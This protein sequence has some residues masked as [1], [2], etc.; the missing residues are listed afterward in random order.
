MAY[1]ALVAGTPFLSSAG[2]IAAIIIC[3][4]SILFI[5]LTLALSVAS[6][7]LFRWINTQAALVKLLRPTVETV[8]KTTAAV[9]RGSA[10]TENENKI[11][12]TIAQGPERVKALDKQV[13]VL[14]DRVVSYAIE[15]RARTLQVQTVARTFFLPGLRQ[16]KGKD[17][18]NSLDRQSL[19]SAEAIKE[20]IPALPVVPLPKTDGREPAASASQR[21]NVSSR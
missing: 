10:P 8:N 19:T 12:R 2:P 16:A 3:I 9:Q 18:A 11:I 20:H 15:F 5:V 13:D 7:L 1:L 6:V 4:Y 21:S 14:S 17:S